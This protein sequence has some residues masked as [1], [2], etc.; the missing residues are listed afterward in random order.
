MKQVARA[1]RALGPWA[2]GNPQQALETRPVQ[3][4]TL[5]PSV[6]PLVPRYF[7]GSGDV[8]QRWQVAVD[9]EVVEVASD[10]AR[11]RGVLLLDLLM[12]VAPARALPGKRSASRLRPPCRTRGRGLGSAHARRGRHI[13]CIPT[14]LP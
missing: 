3:T 14:T 7:V 8:P 13:H 11:E 2:A 4:R 10:A 9:P 1:G 5:A 12:P 6:Q